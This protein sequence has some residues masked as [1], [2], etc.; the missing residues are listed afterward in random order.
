MSRSLAP[1][2]LDGQ[3]ADFVA[4]RS[5]KLKLL[6]EFAESREGEPL[7]PEDLLVRWPTD[8]R[9]DPDVASVLFADYQRRRA[10]GETLTADD[11]Q[12]RF[13]E[14]KDSLAG[15]LRQHEVMRSLGEA[16][17]A[18]KVRLVLP[19]VG[20]EVFGFRLRH[21]LGSGAFARVF[22][23]EQ[24]S[25]A[26]RPVV[27][28]TSDLSGDEPQTLAQL[29]HT[30]IVP[31]YSV[32]EDEA[33]GLRVVCMPYFGGASL[34]EV[35]KEVW[36]HT[37]RPARGSELAEALQ[38]VQ[39]PVVG[40]APQ[41]S[42]QTPLALLRTL[43]YPQAAAWVVARLAEGLEHAHQRGVLHSDIKP[44]NV[45]LAADGTPLLLD[46]NL[47]RG[48]RDGAEAVLGGTIAYMAPEHLRAL[49]ARSAALTQQVDRRS[50]LYSLGMVLF[51]LLTGHNPFDQ[52]GSYSPVPIL[53]E[54]M[55]V[56]RARAAPSLREKRPDVPWDLESI[57]RK[58]LDPDPARRYQRAEEFAED[59]RRFLT[60]RPLKFAPQLSRADRLRKWLRRHPRLASSGG[61]AAAAAVLLGIAAAAFVG[62]RNHLESTREELGEAQSQERK[63]AYQDGATRVLMLVNANTDLRD[64]TRQGLAVC[65][66]TLALYGVLDRDDWQDHPD[67]RWLDDA[68]RRRLGEDTRELL[69]LLARARVRLSPGDPAVL[70]DAL[71]LL[72]RA[73]AIDGLPPSPALW[74]D[75]ADYRRQL[76]DDA[77]A[78][79]ALEHAATLRPANARDHYQLA[80]AFA[81]AGDKGAGAR[82]IAELDR[83]IDLNPQ[84]YWAWFQRGVCHQKAGE[85]HLAAADFGACVGLWP[86]FA[87]GHFNLGCAHDQAGQK[88]SAVRAYSAAIARDAEF[89]DA[90]L[91][92]G[93]A[94]LALGRPEGALADFTRAAALRPGDPSLHA[95][96]GMALEGLGRTAEADAAFGDAFAKLTSAPPEVQGRIRCG[97]GFAVARRLSEKARQAFAAV[98]ER[99][100]DHAEALYGLALIAAERGRSAEAVGHLQ[101]AV[102]AAPGLM[103]AR[104]HLAIQLARCGRF[105]EAFSAINW[106][107]E[108]EPQSGAAM[109]AAACVAAR[110]SA[111]SPETAERAIGL[112]RAAFARG[113]GRDGARQDPDLSALRD[114]P[115][116][117]R[118]FTPHPPGV[119]VQAR[120]ASEGS[121]TPR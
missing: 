110:A 34:S 56:E 26:G 108:R 29:Q 117:R 19:S 79:A 13:P 25:L 116:F 9:A 94:L 61:V 57:L 81:R 120:S 4:A 22:L 74:H 91:N 92:R 3:E 38:K 20:D 21:E 46:F 39:A 121:R 60:D 101:R 65:E 86:E 114:H 33:A 97:Y 14:H 50:D 43:T 15:L 23:G 87:W 115:E 76:G 72:G 99:K 93:M 119:P 59:L 100:S 118:L 40:E 80:A 36:S 44:S 54:A 63:R 62:V 6:S 88:E 12:E 45:L 42:N 2:P 103:E 58:C 32:H 55:A 18:P 84:Y 64:H 71:A 83:S 68:D 47:A 85:H 41:A 106:C 7:R 98:L 1:E 37:D 27:L 73:E 95:G 104:R 31:I 51:E 77:G 96:R 66:K 75:R 8:P 53:L 10:Q 49:N 112:L 16:S 109:Y 70:R 105:A 107:L 113:Y 67:W 89:V 52:S 69:Q 28:K 102:A 17:S 35:L 24:A 11:Y 111:G 78:K 82:A 30:H 90:Y 48:P 5:L